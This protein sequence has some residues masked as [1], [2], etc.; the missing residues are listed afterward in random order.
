M[1]SAVAMMIG[2]SVD[3][4]SESTENYFAFS[5]LGKTQDGEEEREWHHKAIEQ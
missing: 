4:A 2:G 1:A 3:N 5:K